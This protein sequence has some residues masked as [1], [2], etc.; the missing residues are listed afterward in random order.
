MFRFRIVPDLEGVPFMKWRRLT[1]ALSM[2]LIAASIV[3]FF[4]RGLNYGIDFR[5]GVMIEIKTPEVVNIASLR[6]GLNDLGLGEVSIQEFGAADDLLI[7][8]ERQDGEEGAQQRAV[9]AVRA[10]LA[11]L[12]DGEIDYRRTEAVGPKVSGELV[13]DGVMAVGF[14]LIAMLIYIWVRFEWQFSIGAVAALVHDVILTIGMFSVTGLE[15]NLATVAAIL[16]IVGYSM[17]D[18]VVVYDRIRE[19]L[20]KFKKMPIEDLLDLSI[21]NTL[22]RTL[23]TSITTMLA[24]LA[25]Y[26]IGGA[27]IADFSFAMI[28]GVL[29]GT[30]SSIYIAGPLL[31]FFQVRAP[32]DKPVEAK[33][34]WPAQSR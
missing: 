31:I 26:F 6:A 30:Y 33:E 16:L 4:S 28:W 5:G 2:V 34:Q 11:E 10:R 17:N 22:S 21:N 23:M 13:Q 19:N 24:L 29:V 9:E 32:E 7:R 8:L 3:L 1:F 14:A 25:L 15:F 18:T 12:I 27:V 20:R